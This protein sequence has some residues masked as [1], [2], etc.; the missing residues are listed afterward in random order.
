MDSAFT[1]EKVEQLLVV[2]KDDVLYVENELL[3]DC[4]LF[5]ERANL[6][7][8]TT[9]KWNSDQE[10]K[11]RNELIL[12]GYSSK[13]IKAYCGQVE[14]FMKY[15]SEKSVSA[16]HRLIQDYSLFL[17]H[18]GCSHS[19]IN[20]AISAIKF[21]SQKVLHQDETVPY[22]RPKKRINSPMCCP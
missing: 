8:E 3:E 6:Q 11:L 12:R 13:T 21:F 19:Y 9:V 15:T 2:F 16:N 20:Q 5:Q 17:L 1:F 14:R 7:K 10:Q 4:Y 22:I 18:K